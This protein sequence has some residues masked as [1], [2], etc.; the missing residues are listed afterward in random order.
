MPTA[1]DDIECAEAYILSCLFFL[2]GIVIIVK[3]LKS[4]QITAEIQA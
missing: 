4:M 1:P 2:V 3:G